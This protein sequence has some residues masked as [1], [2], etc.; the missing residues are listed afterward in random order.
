MTCFRSALIFAA[1]SISVGAA[2]HRVDALEPAKQVLATLPDV[3][4]SYAQSGDDRALERGRELLDQT[5]QPVLFQAWLAQ[6]E[7]RFDDARVLLD[8]LL[9][10]QPTHAQAWL[11]AASVALA[12]GDTDGSRRACRQVAIVVD[13]GVGFACLARAANPSDW[14]AYFERLARWPLS[15]LEPELA[16]WVQATL[17]ELAAGLARA[18]AAELYFEHALRLAPSVQL[19]AS[20]ADWLLSEE[21][22]DDALALLP[23]RSHAPALGVLRLLALRGLGRDTGVLEQ[24]YER[25]FAHWLEHDDFRHGR[26]MARFY[27]DVADSPALA[28]EIARENL[29]RQSE[30]ED[31]ALLARCERAVDSLAT[32]V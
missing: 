8:E 22:F 31:H 21:R 26:E 28:L 9:T 18:E 10:R 5:S 14:L 32:D 29:L 15:G 24:R 27:L 13:P 25:R 4:R 12:S 3:V 16:G 17:A 23:R 11:L 19:R 6:A 2:G 20:Y 1:L 30:R 7:H